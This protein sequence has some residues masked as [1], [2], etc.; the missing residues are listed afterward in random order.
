MVFFNL[1]ALGRIHNRPE[2]FY[3]CGGHSIIKRC[4][5]KLNFVYFFLFNYFS[6]FALQFSLEK[7]TIYSY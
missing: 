6:N 3:L 1:I 2:L 4:G 7:I 5:T